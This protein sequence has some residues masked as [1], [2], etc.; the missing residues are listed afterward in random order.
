MRPGRRGCAS[1]N[2]SHCVYIAAH[3]RCCFSFC[4]DCRRSSPCKP[5]AEPESSGDERHGRHGADDN[6]SYDA[7]TWTA[8]ATALVVL[9]VLPALCTGA[10]GGGCCA[11]CR[12]RAAADNTAAD[13]TAAPR[14]CCPRRDDSKDCQ[15]TGIDFSEVFQTIIVCPGF[16]VRWPRCYDVYASTPRVARSRGYITRGSVLRDPSK[17]VI[18]AA[19][20]GY[21]GPRLRYLDIS[22]HESLQCRLILGDAEV[23]VGPRERC[24]LRS[25]V[26]NNKP[27]RI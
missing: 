26:V 20:E 15:G 23:G 17:G 3:T 12:A 16:S 13:N 25:I 4:R 14:R 8:A 19:V 2:R 11:R 1:R 21:P 7:G 27:N 6:S 5:E 18:L 24:R 10:L 9:A 22:C